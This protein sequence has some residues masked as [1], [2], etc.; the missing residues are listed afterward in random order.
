MKHLYQREWV[1]FDRKKG[2][3]G[4]KRVI[5][6]EKEKEM[7]SNYMVTILDPITFR[8]LED[9]QLHGSDYDW[10]DL[11]I[12]DPRVQFWESMKVI[13]DADW[14]ITGY[15]DNRE[16]LEVDEHYIEN[17]HEVFEKLRKIFGR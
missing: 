2:L 7:H 1:V 9:V 12:D 17:Q 10:Y 5:S 14:Y 3:L 8:E 13:H 4:V 6:G 15:M 16:S 11:P